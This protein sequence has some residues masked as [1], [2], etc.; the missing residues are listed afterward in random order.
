MRNNG[1]ELAKIILNYSVNEKINRTS[2][3][4]LKKF[5]ELLS[6]AEDY[7]HA[8]VDRLYNKVITPLSS[9]G[10][11]VKRVKVGNCFA[12]IVMRF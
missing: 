1:D 10:V 4:M 6:K 2:A 8:Q 5:A 12:L 11:E 9:Y 7:R 3:C